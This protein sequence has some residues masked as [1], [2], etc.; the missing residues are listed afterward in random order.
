MQGGSLRDQAPKFEAAG[1]DV[2]GL[3]FDTLEENKAFREDNDFPFR[4]L[5][6]PDKTVGTAYQVLRDADDPYADYPRR[7][8]YLVDPDGVVAAADE[9]TDPAGYGAAALVTLAAA[10]R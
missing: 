7:V 8:A 1:C 10:Q 5:S 6:D 3:S 2:V 9:V 4:L